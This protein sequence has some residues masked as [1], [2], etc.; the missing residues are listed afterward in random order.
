MC[1]TYEKV[2]LTNE[3]WHY[4]PSHDQVK[5]FGMYSEWEGRAMIAV[6]GASGFIGRHL[7]QALRDWKLP[8]VCL[9]R[10]SSRFSDAVRPSAPSVPVR[11][12]NFEDIE[13]IQAGLNGCRTLIHV[14][15]LINGTDETL[16]K[17][18]VTITGNLVTA[19]GRLPSS[20]EKFIFVSS[21]AAFGSHGPYG[22][23]KLKAEALIKQSGLP[24]LIF[25]PTFIYGT[26]DEQNTDMMI[27]TL[28]RFPI[29]PL[30]GG[31]GFKL[32]PV[33]VKDAVSVIVQS[34]SLP[35]VNETYTIAGPEQV[36]LK[37][38]LQILSG[39][40]GVRRVMVPIPLGPVKA[41]FRMYLKF[42]KNTRLPAKQILELDKHVAFDI[43]K[44]REDFNF[45]PVVFREGIRRTIDDKY[46]R[47]AL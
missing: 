5:L 29:I 40:I 27:R 14:L 22:Q 46:I 13:S 20:L 25:R 4:R 7:I 11:T 41:F 23:S 21:A 9:A 38:I 31:G 32:Q 33:Y 35:L 44:T 42:F 18:N 1:L 16:F 37:T 19:A 34:V 26:G 28:K 36:S 47:K 2:E 17:T 45:N 3:R 12:V 10:S 39:A 8:F 15:G 6:T 24:Y 43:S 30:L